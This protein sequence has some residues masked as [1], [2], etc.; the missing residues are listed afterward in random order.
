MTP[1]QHIDTYLGEW[2]DGVVNWQL[3]RAGSVNP[4]D[5][6]VYLD[7]RLEAG[8]FISEKGNHH[9]CMAADLLLRRWNEQRRIS[10]ATA[11][12]C[13]IESHIKHLEKVT[14][15]GTAMLSEFALIDGARKLIAKLERDDGL[16]VLPVVF[17]PKAKE[18]FFRVG[19]VSLMSKDRFGDEHGEAIRQRATGSA[20]DRK[21]VAAWRAY[22]RTY[23][24]FIAVKIDKHEAAMAWEVTREAADY[25][26]N[27]IRMTFGYRR[28]RNIKIGDGYI[29]EQ[30]RTTVVFS[31]SGQ[32]L[33]SSTSGPWGSHLEDQWMADLDGELQGAARLLSSFGQWIVSA[34]EP[35]SPVLQRL[36][37]ANALLSEAYSEPSDPIRLVRLISALEAMAVLPGDGKRKNLSDRCARVG[38]S[39]DSTLQNEIRNSVENAYGQRNAVVH[40][41]APPH[42]TVMDAFVALERHILPI[43]V[44]FLK[45]H[46]CIYK[47]CPPQSMRHF[48]KLVKAHF[49]D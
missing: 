40:G 39:G 15:T 45:L 23:D 38:G 19:P 18:S 26:L 25:M 7:S 31:K 12:R 41:D 37:Y 21:T 34:A 3:P 49:D 4:S 33:F 36:L 28:T 6:M 22:S 5:G 13:L 20:Q 1:E 24:H 44:G 30:F 2:V 46:A 35:G 42:T 11:R 32:P 10:A 8:S 17:G 27:L 16:Y 29:Q 48:R 14:R 9:L 47:R 43:Y